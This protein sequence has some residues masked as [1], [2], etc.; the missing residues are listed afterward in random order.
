VLRPE[1]ITHILFDMDGVLLDTEPLYTKSIQAV[2]SRFGKT[3]DWG[4]KE[5]IMGRGRLAAAAFLVDALALPLDAE[6][7]LVER[8]VVL[9][10]LLAE[11][12]EIPGAE[13][14]TRGLHQ[15][16][17]KLAVATSS[18][19]RLFHHKTQHH[20]DWFSIF[21]AVVCGDDPRLTHTKPAPDI[22]LIA[23]R[24]LGAEPACCLVFEDS[25]AGIQ[26]ALAAGMRVVALPDP[27]LDPALLAGAH[28]IIR[29]YHEFPQELLTF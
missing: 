23:A 4:L 20:Q 1:P 21:S 12:V 18:E 6:T 9:M 17:L 14:F 15:R 8:D 26:A 24:E 27:N 7:F 19:R 11:A 25:P 22:F 3:F 5:Q 10:D 28:H 2:T 29:G 16:G 13:A